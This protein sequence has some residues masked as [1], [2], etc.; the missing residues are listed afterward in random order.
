LELIFHRA[1][2]DANARGHEYATLEHLLRALIDDA[3]ASAVMKACKVDL[4]ALKANL[5]ARSIT[6]LGHSRSTT[7]AIPHRHLP[8]SGS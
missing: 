2:A 5:P 6:S 8:F 4:G 1:I 7:S 3:N